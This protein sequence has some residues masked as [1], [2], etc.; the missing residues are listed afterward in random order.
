MKYC[1]YFDDEDNENFLKRRNGICERN[2]RRKSFLEKEIKF[3]R[4]KQRFLRKE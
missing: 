1:E 4:K 3:Q 2:E